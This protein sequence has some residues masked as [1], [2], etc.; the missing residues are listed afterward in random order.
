[1]NHLQST[2][3]VQKL[4]YSMY[5]HNLNV[6]ILLISIK[7]IYS[8]HDFWPKSTTKYYY[9][10]THYQIVIH[11]WKK[12]LHENVSRIIM[13]I[14]NYLEAKPDTPT[15]CVSPLIKPNF[16]LNGAIIVSMC[17][18]IS[19]V[20]VGYSVARTPMWF[21]VVPSRSCCIQCGSNPKRFRIYM[22]KNTRH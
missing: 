4:R 5:F 8:K 19:L 21:R 9:Y 11:S 16:N 2:L 17:I 22:I 13:L 15:I 10:V 20:H 6:C 12:Y 18:I 7:R 3:M 14:N 1:M